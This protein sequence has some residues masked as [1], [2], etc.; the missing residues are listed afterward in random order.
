MT[1]RYDTQLKEWTFQCEGTDFSVS[2]VRFN[3]E[4][5]GWATEAVAT[6]R[7]LETVVRAR[8]VECLGDWPCDKTKAQILS[9]NLDEY[10]ES[11]TMDVAFIGDESWGDFGV[12]VIIKDGQIV[13]AYGGD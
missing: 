1:A 12:N 7:S 11:K 5:F 4:A 13:D 8:V 6:L 9:V 2:G 10:A 3:E